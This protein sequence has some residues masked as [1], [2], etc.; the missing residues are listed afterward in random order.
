MG[1]GYTDDVD[2][3][4]AALPVARQTYLMSATLGDDVQKL[5]T[6]AMNRPAMVRMEEEPEAADEALLHQLS[7]RAESGPFLRRLCCCFLLRVV[8]CSRIETR[9][10][11]NRNASL[12]R[13]KSSFFR[14]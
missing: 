4:V 13:I 12:F 2:A 7:L 14:I 8:L 1:Y 9:F 11:S 10:L 6:Q 5:Q 3:I